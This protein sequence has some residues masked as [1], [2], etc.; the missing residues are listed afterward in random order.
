MTSMSVPDNSNARRGSFGLLTRTGWVWAGLLAV[1]YI[2][3]HWHLIQRMVM[4]GL[5]DQNWSHILVV[6]LISVYYIHLHRDRLLA[7][8]RR[9]CLWGLPLMILGVF[10]FAVGVAPIRNDM[11]MG[12]SMILSLFGLVLLLTG[13]AMM[14]I[15]WFPIAFLVFA[16]KVSD[17]IWNLIASKLQV[18]AAQGS[19]IVLEV[20]SPITDLHANLRGSTIDLVYKVN[21]LPVTT[22]MNVAEACS[23]LRMLMAFLALGVAL[24][25][26][27]PRSWWQRLIMI[28]LAA[29]IAVFVNVLRV[30][31]LG[32]LHLIDPALA[33]DDFHIFVGMLMLIPAAGLLMLVGWC[34]DRIIITEGKA[35][36]KPV[37]IP[38]TDDPDKLHVNPPSTLRGL[39]IG[40]VCM[41]VACGVYGLLLNIAIGYEW[42]SA[43]VGYALLAGF[44]GAL[45]AA[46]VFVPRFMPVADQVPG[47]SRL[48]AAFGIGLGV[49]LLA[50][51]TQA[52]MINAAN[53]AM[54]KEA[55]PLR[56]DLRAAFPTQFDN[57]DFVLQQDRLNKNI[58]SELGTTKYF[59]RWYLDTE[60]GL[61]V[62]DIRNDKGELNFSQVQG[63][64]IAELHMAYY[65]GMADTVPHVPD[66]CWLAGGMDFVDKRVVTLELD[67]ADWTED[68]ASENWLAP[69]SFGAPARVPSK[70]IKAVMFVAADPEG[71]RQTVVY[72]FVANGKFVATSHQVRGMAFDLRDRH[73]Y[74]C[75][76]EVKFM[77]LED[78]EEV[79]VR[80][81]AFLNDAMPEVMAS[82][83]D[84][85]EVKA[86]RYPGDPASA[87]PDPPEDLP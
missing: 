56:H 63:G 1:A 2:F 41:A 27:F 9:V 74:Y 35:K 29:P 57:W 68:P 17:A 37:P 30:S 75:K 19:V 23:G 59:N 33:R 81:T 49:L 11:A 78:P 20:L 31:T 79:L 66:V 40:A 47:G 39:G 22:P 64:D 71:R 87:S 21:G 34:L 26:L 50:G 65:T 36:A 51:L 58:E 8:P 18:V 54:I 83:P 70:T 77:G 80:A 55:V 28:A 15:L 86:G 5:D 52:A 69:S 84:W 62:S 3:L 46:A 67:G 4:I 44:I 85:V 32:L 60:T 42:L 45:V 25:F 6:P 43:G 24:A 61:T 16:I 10:G 72:F 53:V 13:P 12:Y 48:H 38:L 82:M 73:S 14:R 7:T 76:V